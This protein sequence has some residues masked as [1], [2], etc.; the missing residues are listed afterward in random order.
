MATSVLKST[1][2]NVFDREKAAAW[3]RQ[4]EIMSKVANLNT[5]Q[6]QDIATYINASANK[7]IDIN[8]TKGNLER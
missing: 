3:S 7:N 6:L 1:L 5:E 4:G 8:Q 2:P